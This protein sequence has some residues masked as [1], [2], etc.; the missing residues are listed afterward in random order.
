MAKNKPSSRKVVRGTVYTYTVLFEPTAEGGYTVTVPLLP[1]VITEGDTLD[2]ARERAREAIRGYLKVLRKYGELIPRE[3]S[4]ELT[5]PI[6]E[7]LR[8]AVN[9]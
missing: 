4:S 1:G 7:R 5:R 2:E 9:A 3:R 6:T 8:I